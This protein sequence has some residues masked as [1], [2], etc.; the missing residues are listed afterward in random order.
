[1]ERHT[2]KI[3]AQVEGGG[4]G[5]RRGGRGERNVEEEKIGSGLA[6]RQAVELSPASV[7]R[8]SLSVKPP[9]MSKRFE[10]SLATVWLRRRWCG[11]Q[12]TAAVEGMFSSSSV[13]GPTVKQSD[14]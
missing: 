6:R 11:K 4:N 14:R 10:P 13:V 8:W 12:P 2:T 9:E 1:M 7:T 5:G 3:G